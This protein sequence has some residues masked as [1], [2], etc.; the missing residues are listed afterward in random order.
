MTSSRRSS[1]LRVVVAGGILL[2]VGL[3]LASWALPVNLRSVSPALLKAAGEGSPSLS[4][5]G[6]QLLEREKLGPAALFAT[7]ARRAG[8]PGLA[9]LSA[10]LAEAGARQ[11]TLVPWGGWDPFLDPLFKLEESKGHAGSTPILT[12]FITGKARATLRSY[13][14]NS[15]SLG[16]QALLRTREV[17]VTGQFVPVKS[18][19][20]QTLEAV[21]LLAALL[22]QG[23]HFSAPLQRDLRNLAEIA[24]GRMDMGA[25]EGVYLDLLSLGKRLDWVQ[26]GELLRLADDRKT[27]GEYAHLARVAPDDFALIYAAALFSGSADR[28]ATYLLRFGKTGLDDLALAARDGQGAVQLLLRQQVPVSHGRGPALSA[29]ARLAL[30]FPNLALAVKWLGFL[31]GSCLLL[32]MVRRAAVGR[33]AGPRP[34][35]TTAILGALCAAL[36]VVFTEPTLFN[37]PPPSEFAIRLAVPVLATLSDPASLKTVEP[38]LAM[39]TTTLISIGLFAIIQIVWFLICLRKI[40]EIAQSSASPQLKLKLME[41]E[42][43]LFDGGL[44]LGIAGTATALVLQVLGLIQPNLLAAYSSNMFGIVCV[45]LIKIRHVRQ[46]KRQ[47]ILDGQSLPDGSSPAPAAAQPGGTS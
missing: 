11:P 9:A 43:N 1:P 7:A 47:L 14:Q 4:E 24:S 3:L 13:L 19:G 22:Y 36:I 26:L 18:P 30:A 17:G 32:E 2:G 6:R 20:G 35:V 44:Y 29:A 38:T 39:D 45:A 41:N 5:F 40:A 21:I 10:R 37:A 8:D 33:P 12:F 15:R 31:A 34:S 27:L 25:L 28:V 16:V 46:F 23:E 42:E